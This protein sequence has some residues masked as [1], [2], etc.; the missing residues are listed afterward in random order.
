MARQ[1]VAVGDL[2]AMAAAPGSARGLGEWPHRTC[3]LNC[4]SRTSRPPGTSLT[5]SPTLAASPGG[6]PT[7]RSP[8]SKRAS[9]P[10][11]TAATITG[12]V[13]DPLRRDLVRLQSALGSAPPPDGAR[14]VAIADH[15][16]WVMDFLHHHHQ[17]EE[18]ACLVRPGDGRHDHC[19][20]AR[21]AAAMRSLPSSHSEGCCLPFTVMS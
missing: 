3:R 10:A 20:L 12:I 17:A 11:Y 6:W 5:T 18:S 19:T 14:R 7:P 8:L 21:A 2:G 1:A 4:C 9:Q 16:R 13:H 15:A